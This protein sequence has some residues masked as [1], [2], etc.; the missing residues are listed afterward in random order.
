[1]IEAIGIRHIS[2]AG[3]NPL[4]DL[5]LPLHEP[6]AADVARM[7]AALK[8]EDLAA[9]TVTPQ[10]LTPSPGTGQASGQE[11]EE[12]SMGDAILGTLN[13]AH[14]SYNASLQS[15][16]DTFT[17]SLS[18]GKNLS[19]GALIAMQFVL[20]QASFVAQTSSK[21]VDSI[22]SGIETLERAQ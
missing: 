20:F 16:Q 10:S 12:K 2:P 13:K 18:S 3:S 22:K 7:Q 15:V 5:P 19:S 14:E 11:Q 17:D 21:V 6:K 9:D 4:V 8:V 1:M